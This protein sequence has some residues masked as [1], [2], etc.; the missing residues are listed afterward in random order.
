MKRSEINAIIRD[1]EALIAG[2]GFAVPPWA[3]WSPQQWQAHPDQA[4]YC[5][6]HQMGW[7]ITDFGGGNFARKGLVLLCIRNGLP[8]DHHD[9]PY[10]EKL[11]IVREGQETPFHFHKVKMEDIICRGGGNLVLEMMNTDAKGN[12]LDTPVSVRIDAALETYRPRQKA[13]LQPGQSVSIPQALMHRFYGEAG[14][15]TVLVGEVSK[16]NDDLKDN[17]FLDPIARF[18][19]IE[20]DEPPYRP[21]W[22]E[23]AH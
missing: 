1:A 7:D 5:A 23:L 2:H 6:Q 4:A 20:E 19:T 9:R 8:G 14:H 18:S 3:S 17:F 11:L 16:V 22:S 10:A 13:V 12:V 21:L 15:G